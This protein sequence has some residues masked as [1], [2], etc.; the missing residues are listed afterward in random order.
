MDA[1][2]ADQPAST[3]Q[4]DSAD[5]RDRDD[6]QD[7]ADQRD[8]GNSDDQDWYQI[9]L[10]GRLDERWSA[11]FDGMTLD[12]D[13]SGTTVLRGPVEDQAALHGLLA[14]LRDLNLPLICVRRVP[15]PSGEEPALPSTS[16]V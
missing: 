16:N 13:A 4:R 6:Q 8:S 1:D 5:Q 3:D 9:E 10:L 14:R 11:W 15:M 12:S 7:N 2:T